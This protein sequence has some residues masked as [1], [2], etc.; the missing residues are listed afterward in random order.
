MNEVL[1]KEGQTLQIKL[2]KLF[3]E[4]TWI[5]DGREKIK[6]PLSDFDIHYLNEEWVPYV[7]L[8]SEGDTVEFINELL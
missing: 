3:K 2:N 7:E 6:A 8:F 1:A 4:I 5:V